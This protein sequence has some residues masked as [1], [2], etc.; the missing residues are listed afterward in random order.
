MVAVAKIQ[1]TWGIQHCSASASCSISAFSVA[2]VVLGI[3]CASAWQLF[4]HNTQSAINDSLS[5]VL[6][7]HQLCIKEVITAGRPFRSIPVCSQELVGSD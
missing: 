1:V 4:K 2:L 7:L 6:R 3:G 5:L